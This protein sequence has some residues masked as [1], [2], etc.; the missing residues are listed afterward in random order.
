V[1]SAAAEPDRPA[2]IFLVERYRPPAS[3][4]DLSASV[5]RMARLCALSCDPR[6]AASQAV[7]YLSSTYVP[8]DDTCFCVFRAASAETVR[9][10][11]SEARFALDRITEAVMLLPGETGTATRL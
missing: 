2:S 3:A 4:A 1:T 8:L 11:N 6:S 5:A 10:L 7:Q 9:A